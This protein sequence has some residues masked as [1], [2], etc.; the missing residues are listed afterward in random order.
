MFFLLVSLM[1]I[2]PVAAFDDRFH[3]SSVPPWVIVLGY[4]LLSVGMFMSTWVEAVNKFAEPGVRIQVE[5]GHK[6]IDTGPY[7]IVR[8]PMYLATFPLIAGMSLAAG[9]VLG[10]D[11][12][13]HHGDC[14]GRANGT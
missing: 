9:I 10:I 12:S 5:R 4:I 3:W 8:H 2:F 6:V 7:A 1:A 14:P 11:P 13:S